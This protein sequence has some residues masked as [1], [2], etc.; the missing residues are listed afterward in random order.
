[1]C[2]EWCRSN[3]SFSA[4]H[5]QIPS[6]LE[7]ELIGIFVQTVTPSDRLRQLDHLFGPFSCVEF[8]EL[9]LHSSNMS[10]WIKRS[11]ISL[12]LAGLHSSCCRINFT[13]IFSNILIFTLKQKCFHNIHQLFLFCYFRIMFLFLSFFFLFT[14]FME[15]K[16]RRC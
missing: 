3:V 7:T 11:I 5:Q 16:R 9:F 10:E 13:C 14:I 4:L 8:E 6:N 12:I 15:S 1:M 2:Q